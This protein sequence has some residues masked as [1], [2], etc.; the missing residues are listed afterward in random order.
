[1]PTLRHA[2][3]FVR[4]FSISLGDDSHRL[5]PMQIYLHTQYTWNKPKTGTEDSRTTQNSSINMSLLSHVGAHRDLQPRGLA[6]TCS[7]YSQA[8]FPEV[9]EQTAGCVK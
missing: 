7:V 5:R 9:P 3:N 4:R 1:M 6:H 8:L 2:W